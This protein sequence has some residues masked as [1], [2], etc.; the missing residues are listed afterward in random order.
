MIVSNEVT[1]YNCIVHMCRFIY[2]YK[3]NWICALINTFVY[4][5]PAT[6]SGRNTNSRN[7][8]L[9]VEQNNASSMHW[10]IKYFFGNIYYEAALTITP[11]LQG[12]KCENDHKRWLHQNFGMLKIQPKSLLYRSMPLWYVIVIRV[13]ALVRKVW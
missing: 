6:I 12:H 2:R 10:Q 8:P 3:R 5:G 4:A 1:V 9:F 11:C 13:E 7:T